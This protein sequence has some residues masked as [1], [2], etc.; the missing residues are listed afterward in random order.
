MEDDDRTFVGSEIV[1]QAG[2]S[3]AV[4]HLT[5]RTGSRARSVI[6]RNVSGQGPSRVRLLSL[7][8]YRLRRAPDP[9]LVAIG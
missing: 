3:P 2:A 9:N 8:A 4:F 7:S 6:V 1:H 5:A